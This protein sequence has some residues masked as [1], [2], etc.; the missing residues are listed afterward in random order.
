MDIKTIEEYIREY[1]KGKSWTAG[2]YLEQYV[3]NK[4][5]TKGET[6]SRRCRE[7]AEDGALENKYVQYKGRNIVQYRLKQK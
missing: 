6:T 2:G 7:M 1:L 3:H 4:K 5:G